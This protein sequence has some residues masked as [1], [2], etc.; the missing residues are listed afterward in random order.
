MQATR[1]EV[2]PVGRDQSEMLN[3]TLVLLPALLLAA[4]LGQEQAPPLPEP[5]PVP[6]QMSPEATRELILEANASLCRS[7]QHAAQILMDTGAL[8]QAIPVV[9]ELTGLGPADLEMRET[10]ACRSDLSNSPLEEVRA[11]NRTAVWLVEVHL[12]AMDEVLPA[13]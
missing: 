11:L 7:I 12:A 2:L 5:P 1:E 10:A 4:V 8:P 13:Q 3:R 6:A 9:G